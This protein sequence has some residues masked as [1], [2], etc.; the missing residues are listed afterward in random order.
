MSLTECASGLF[1]GHF[2]FG[3]GTLGFCQCLVNGVGGGENHALAP[4]SAHLGLSE[5]AHLH[6]FFCQHFLEVVELYGV[7]VAFNHDGFRCRG[8]IETD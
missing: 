5:Y 8:A 2:E 7:G 6:P 4:V 3:V 1:H